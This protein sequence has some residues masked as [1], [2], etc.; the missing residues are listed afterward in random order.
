MPVADSGA[1]GHLI[2]GYPVKLWPSPYPQPIVALISRRLSPVIQ[3]Y[4]ITAVKPHQTLSTGFFLTQRLSIVHSSSVFG[5]QQIYVSFK[6]TQPWAVVQRPSPRLV[7]RLIRGLM[8]LKQWA[9]EI[10]LFG[11]CITFMFST[12]G[13]RIKDN[14]G[15]LQEITD[16]FK[17]MQMP[18]VTGCNWEVENSHK[19]KRK[20]CKIV[21]E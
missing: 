3:I 1:S 4:R 20:W 6:K 21:Q 7:S 5:T 13:G 9:L 19:S 15:A 14:T 18:F 16:C 17:N 8:C 12:N 11:Q 10:A 2:Q